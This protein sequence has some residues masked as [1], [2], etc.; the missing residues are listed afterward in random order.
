MFHQSD[1]CFH[2]QNDFFSELANPYFHFFVTYLIA[3]ESRFMQFATGFTRFFHLLRCIVVVDVC[4]VAEKF[5]IEEKVKACGKTR[6]DDRWVKSF[7]ETL[8]MNYELFCLGI[9][10]ILTHPSNLHV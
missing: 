2:N 8:K 3:E 4:K 9:K 5:L 7:V 10:T 1:F 6:L